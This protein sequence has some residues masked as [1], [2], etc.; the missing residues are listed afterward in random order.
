[1]SES[2]PEAAAQRHHAGPAGGGGSTVSTHV[3]DAVAG[4]PGPGI[5]VGLTDA[6]GV[7]LAT[8]TTDGDGRTGLSPAQPLAPGVYRLV[9]ATGAYFHSRGQESFFPEVV[10]TFE[11]AEGHTHIPM[12]LSPFAYS[13]YR[14]S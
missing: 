2:G 10:I 1:M 6:R 12:L 3:L 4:R 14:G 8:A 5:V 13:T 9:F 11:A 7:V